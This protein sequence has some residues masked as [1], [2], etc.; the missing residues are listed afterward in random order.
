MESS[1]N[2]HE[3]LAWVVSIYESLACSLDALESKARHPSNVVLGLWKNSK[4]M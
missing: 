4:C 2:G 3:A 1:P